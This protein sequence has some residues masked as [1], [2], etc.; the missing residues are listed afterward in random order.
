MQRCEEGYDDLGFTRNLWIDRSSD[1]LY[2][3]ATWRLSMT[4][5]TRETF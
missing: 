4:W 3:A 2:P 5:D 1:I